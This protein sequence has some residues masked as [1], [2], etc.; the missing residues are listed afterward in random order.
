M[1]HSQNVGGKLIKH[2]WWWLAWLQKLPVRADQWV[3]YD[4]A[5]EYHLSAS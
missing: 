5:V 3:R 1:A 2:E 4:P